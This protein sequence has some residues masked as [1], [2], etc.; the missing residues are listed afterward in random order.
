M[1]VTHIIYDEKTDEVFVGIFFP[2]ANFTQVYSSTGEYKRKIAVPGVS[3]DKVINFDEH[4]LFVYSDNPDIA[5]YHKERGFPQV[6]GNN[7]DQFL[8][9]SKTD[10]EVI[11]NIKLPPYELVFIA[12]DG[13]MIMKPKKL[14]K[15][16]EGVLICNPETDT[17]YL[18]S[19][20]RLLTPVL[21]KTPPV[22]H[23]DPMVILNN[24]MDVGRYQ[25]MELITMIRENGE[26]PPVKYLFRD[27][28][29]GEIFRQKI[30]IPEYKGEEFYIGLH[31][32][33]VNDDNTIR[34]ELDLC[35][36]KQAYREGRLSGGLKELVSTLKDDDNNVFMMVS[37]K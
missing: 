29:S 11:D 36:L 4:S 22:T 14:V 25:F 34:Y 19:K 33:L 9:I 13:C 31:R 1:D 35:E 20:D 27:K 15:C 6:V 18:Y 17:V 32:F 21:Y 24:C 10:G 2:F 7:Y 37:F 12:S 8:L 28:N 16:P 23:S 26:Y 30:V 3:F 5:K